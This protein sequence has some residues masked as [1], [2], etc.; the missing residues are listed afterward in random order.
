LKTVT[1]TVHLHPQATQHPAAGAVGEGPC[2]RTS[3]DA[4]LDE[5]FANLSDDSD[6]LDDS[7]GKGDSG[8][9][10]LHYHYPYNYY[11]FNQ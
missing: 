5:Y 10:L 6:Y 8:V 4:G 11:N 1:V 9:R 2:R 3:L 7:D